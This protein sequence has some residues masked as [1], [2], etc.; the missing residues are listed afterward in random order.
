MIAAMAS[1]SRRAMGMASGYSRFRSAM[2]TLI[3]RIAGIRAGMERA[4][5]IPSS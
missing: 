5:R 1:S 2:A 4:M 3:A